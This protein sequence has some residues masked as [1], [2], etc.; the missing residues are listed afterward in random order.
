MTAR[1]ARITAP[2]T[3]ALA[4]APL[5]GRPAAAA[6][7][8]DTSFEASVREYF[9]GAMPNSQ[10]ASRVLTTLKKR[11]HSLDNTLFGTSICSDE[12]N[13]VPGSMGAILQRGLTNN[14]GGIFNLGGLGGLPFVGKSGFGAF[15]SHCPV[16]GKVVIMFGPHVGISQSGIV[17]KVERVGMT[18]LS[19]AC[20]AGIGAYKA[21][22]QAKMDGNGVQADWSKDRQEEWIVNELQDKLKDGE[23]GRGLG[24]GFLNNGQ[25]ATVTY[26]TYDLVWDL[27]KSG[28]D[29]SVTDPA[30]WEKV[31]E[32]TLL[33]GVV[34]NQGHYKGSR[35][36]MMEDYFQPFAFQSWR[37]QDL[38]DYV[39]VKEDLLRNTFQMKNPKKQLGF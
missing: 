39:L 16:D 19:T 18:K 23:L 22:L 1:E 26:R 2:A 10:V 6:A 28:L 15:F 29:T 20:G 38:D 24:S 4:A 25:M 5:L 33:G 3:A 9:P 12:I 21:L 36:A 17:G 13:S 34:I 31:T 14:R 27:M 11:G 7:I 8:G 32:V 35:K 30:F 37:A